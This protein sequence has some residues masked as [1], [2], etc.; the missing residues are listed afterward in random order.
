MLAEVQLDAE[1]V[2]PGKRVG[3]PFARSAVGDRD[4]SVTTLSAVT[5]WLV[6]AFAVGASSSAA[7]VIVTVSVVVVVPSLTATW[8]VRL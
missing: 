2:D 8:K 4:P 1:P 3:E 5:V 6:P 7:T